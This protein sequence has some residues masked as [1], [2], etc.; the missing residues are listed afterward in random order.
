MARPPS[1]TVVRQRMPC[2]CICHTSLVQLS[3]STP[4]GLVLAQTAPLWT[5]TSALVGLAVLAAIQ[6][7]QRQVPPPLGGMTTHPVLRA[8][9]CLLDDGGNLA[10]T[11]PHS[12]PHPQTALDAAI[13]G[14]PFQKP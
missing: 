4:I 10:H 7:I 12:K 6:F 9:A 13:A 5:S 3:P 2:S 8:L 11:D 1:L 14:A